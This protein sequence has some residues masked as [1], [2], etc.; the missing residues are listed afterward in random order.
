MDQIIKKP[1]SILM[2][3]PNITGSLHLGHAL[4]N[5][6]QDCLVRYYHLR[7]HQTVWI[8]GFDHAGIATEIMVQKWIKKAQIKVADRVAEKQLFAKWAEDHQTQIRQQWKQLGLMINNEYETFTLSTEFQKV[9]QTAFVKLY[10]K[11]LIYRA[12]KLVNWDPLL[13]TA[14]ADIEIDHRLTNGK[15]YYVRYNLV[16]PKPQ[17]NYLVVA[18][19]RPETIFADQA[20]V[21]HPND[22]RYRDLKNQLAI[23][24]LNQNQIPI[25]TD[26]R[27]DRKFGSGVLK[28][29][30][31]HDF[32]DW[33]IGQKNGLQVVVCLDKTGHLNEQGL[34]FANYER[35]QARNLIVKKL[36]A[37]GL[38]EKITDYQ[39]NQPYS[40]RSG[41]VIEPLPST[42][43]FLKTGQWKQAILHQKD[44]I[45]FIPQKYRKNLLNW[46]NKTHDWCI[47]RQLR[48]GHKIPVY[49]H[50]HTN[51]VRVSLTTLDPQTWQASSDVLDTWFSSGLYGIAN[52]GWEYPER[53][54]LAPLFPVSYLVTSY[55]IIF[56]WVV[57]MFFFS[58]EFQ[59]QIPF[60]K[61][62]IHGLV[63]TANNRKM[64]KSAGNAV[65]PEKLITKYSSDAL[66]VYFLTNHRIGDDIKFEES[67]LIQ[68]QQFLHKLK[69]IAI[70]LEP[71]EL[72]KAVQTTLKHP[73]N[74]WFA[75]EF[76][77]FKTDYEQLF[78]KALFSV[79]GQSSINFIWKNLSNFYLLFVKTLLET[80]YRQE[81]MFLLQQIWQQSLQLL[82]PFMPFTTEKLAQQIW[83][84]PLTSTVICQWKLSQKPH[85]Y[86]NKFANELRNIMAIIHQ[87]RSDDPKQTIFVKWTTDDL[88]YAQNHLNLLNELLKPQKAQIQ[89][90]YPGKITHFTILESKN[91]ATMQATIR[92][93]IAFYESEL[94]RSKALM[95]NQNFLQKAD[96]KLV[97]KEQ[98]KHQNNLQ[99]LR[100]WKNKLK[101]L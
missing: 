26:R 6:L 49:F 16:A 100:F 33:E 21:V 57:R 29:T 23:N 91:I 11:K 60:Q 39:H 67:K 46:I 98:T 65:N 44:A 30:P 75:Q 48:W 22:Q 9:V 80:V 51:V 28:C 94:V 97:K 89:M 92:S 66:R 56:F 99:S 76:Q 54:K 19:T 83:S 73:L 86:L 32:Q 61:I 43:W 5:F 35:F 27:V 95:T 3:P 68:A 41:V 50:R 64:S 42:Q 74:R 15:L 31:G 14:I 40:Q 52:F 69:H 37:S 36:Q 78:S 72:A 47:S 2:P 38:I 82:H 45:N 81:T 12:K 79:V 18:T 8:P 84:Q 59:K 93:K 85:A 70:F 20:L 17:L 10:E 101:N 58:L 71:L 87:K 24:P 7:G 90:V 96:V 34:E 88:K 1:I 55:D 4:N 53:R 77:I 25:I 62:I 13:Q 63:R